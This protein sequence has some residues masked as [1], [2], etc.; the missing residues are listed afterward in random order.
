MIDLARRMSMRSVLVRTAAVVATVSTLLGTGATSAEAS[1]VPLLSSETS[2][3]H[4]VTEILRAHPDARLLASNTVLIEP[5]VSIVVLPATPIPAIYSCPFE[6]L[7]ISD[8]PSWDRTGHYV[9]N[10]RTC[11]FIDLGRR[12]YPDFKYVG[13][14]PGPK[15]NDRLSSY[16]NNQ[17]KG[18]RS[19]FYD[20]RSGWT[21]VHT[22]GGA[23]SAIDN[24]ADLAVDNLIDGVQ[25]C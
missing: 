7:C 19:R 16:N 11:E 13:T 18:T 5:G 15:W 17:T 14:I 25:V 4:R 10:L 3:D 12:S 20:W 2:T 6:Y 21:R 24:L 22:S 23:P 1:Q 9:I 8:A